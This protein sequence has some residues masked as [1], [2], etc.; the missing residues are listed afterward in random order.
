MKKIAALTIMAVLLASASLRAESNQTPDSAIR[1]RKDGFET[2]LKLSRG[3]YDELKSWSPDRQLIRD[4]AARLAGLT[5][6]IPTWFPSGSGQESGARTNA[7]PEIWRN[8]DDFRRKADA[9]ITAAAKIDQA[10]KSDNFD[11]IKSNRSALVETCQD[12]HASYQ[13]RSW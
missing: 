5:R 7:R 9:L 2:I 4:D 11:A 6:Q 10:A 12:C 3:I 1:L 8:A 13:S